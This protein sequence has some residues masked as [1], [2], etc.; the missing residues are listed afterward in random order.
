MAS[1]SSSFSCGL[2]R[3]TFH[4]SSSDYGLCNSY[5]GICDTTYPNDLFVFSANRR[6]MVLAEVEIEYRGRAVR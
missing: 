5:F 3:S 1:A 4:V 2:R 6:G